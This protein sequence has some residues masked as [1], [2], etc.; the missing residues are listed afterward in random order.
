VKTHLTD[1]SQPNGIAC[2][3]S[4]ARGESVAD[5]S[6]VTCERCLPDQHEGRHGR[7]AGQPAWTPGRR[8]PSGPTLGD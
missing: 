1:P 6:L 7:R 3:N 2:N 5:V 8:V 4:R